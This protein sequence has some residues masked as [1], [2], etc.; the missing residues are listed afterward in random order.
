MRTVRER[1]SA[2]AP[3]IVRAVLRSPGQPLDNATRRTMEPRFGHDFSSVRVHHDERA[4]ESARA[5]GALA[6]TAGS[7]IVF[8]TA[9]YAPGS[10]PG[11]QILKHELT[12]VVQNADGR[13]ARARLAVH[14]R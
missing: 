10:A 7:D 2:P 4:A 1:H 11:R 13:R 3:P 14:D 12:H 5:V 8:D 9:R 6:Y